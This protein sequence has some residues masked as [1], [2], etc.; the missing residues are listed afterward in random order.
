MAA[1]RMQTR[2]K[3]ARSLPMA[4]TRRTPSAC[5]AFG[6]EAMTHE[7]VSASEARR[8]SDRQEPWPKCDPEP[9]TSGALLLM[10]AFDRD[11]TSAVVGRVEGGPLLGAV[12]LLQM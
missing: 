1:R 4:T 2:S 9:T 3:I 8:G 10:F 6:V 12:A 5:L 7:A 11:R